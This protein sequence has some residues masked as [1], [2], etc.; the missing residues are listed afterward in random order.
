[1]LVAARLFREKSFLATTLDD[2]AAKIGINKATIYS[3]F[4]SKEQL[5]YEILT[6]ALQEYVE[7]ARAILSTN[8]SPLEKMESLVRTH[9]SIGTRPNSLNAVSLFERKNLSTR[10]L[11]QYNAQRDSYEQMFRDVLKEGIATNS[12]R[13]GDPSMMSRFVLSLANSTIMWFKKAGPLS[14]GQVA[15]ETWGFVSRGLRNRT[16]HEAHD[17]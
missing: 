7:S 4:K 8:G 5:L 2:V 6:G 11:K 17:G 16:G 3:Y 10:L 14:I 9:L 15:D 13:G 1:M 12:F